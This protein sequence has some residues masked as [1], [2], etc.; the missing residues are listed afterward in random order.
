MITFVGQ[1]IIEHP[2]H[3][4]K[5]LRKALRKDSLTYL[6]DFEVED[7]IARFRK[8]GHKIKLYKLTLHVEEI[9]E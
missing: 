3:I 2:N 9:T 7:T 1:T 8:H 5:P 4:S 6:G